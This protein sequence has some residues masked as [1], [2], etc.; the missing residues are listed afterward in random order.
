MKD[1][2]NYDG[3]IL[4]VD[5]LQELWERQEVS[6]IECCGIS[7]QDPSLEWYVVTFVDGTEISVY[8]I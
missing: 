7:G 6:T 1:L 5:Q 2:K 8:S 3:K 4:T